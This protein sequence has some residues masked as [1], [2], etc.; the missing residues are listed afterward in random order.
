[1]TSPFIILFLTVVGAYLFFRS[2][3]S[4]IFKTLKK[5]VTV[6][7]EIIAMIVKDMAF[8]FIRYIID[9]VNTTSVIDTRPFL[10]FF[11]VFYSSEVPCH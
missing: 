6:T 3:V 11:K 2:S 10:D 8:F 5:S 1:M 7:A 9:D 4:L